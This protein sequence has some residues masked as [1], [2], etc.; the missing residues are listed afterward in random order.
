MLNGNR[1]LADYY[2]NEGGDLST[3]GTFGSGNNAD[4]T[5]YID[6]L[7][8]QDQ[9]GPVV[10]LIGDNPVSIER[11]S[12]YADAGATAFDAGDNAGKTVTTS[13]T[14]DTT[15][16]G[17]YTLTYTAT[18]SRGNIGTATRSVTVNAPASTPPTVSSA[19][20]S[21]VTSASA[22]LG[23]SVQSAGTSDIS[24]RGFV[25]STADTTLEIGAEGVTAVPAEAGL[26]AFTATASGLADG[27]L[28]YFRA[29]ATNETGTSYGEILTFTTLKAEPLVHA[30]DFAA[31]T[32]NSINIAA[33][34]SPVE[35]D[36][37]LLVVSSGAQTAP[38]DGIAVA[39]DTDVSD[40]SAAV[41]LSGTAGSYDAFTGFAV[42]ETYTFRLYPFNNSGAAID[43]KTGSAPSFTAAVLT[44]PEL[45]A[46]GTPAALTT[47]YGTPSAATTFTVSGVYLTSTVS[48]AAPTGFEVSADNATYGPSVTLTPVSGTLAPTMIY[49][50]LAATAAVTGAY[51][52][53][54]IGIDGGGATSV[55]LNT[56]AGGHAV[57]PKALGIVGLS[58]ADKTYDGTTDAVVAGTPLYEGLVNNE[59]FA[60]TGGVSWAFPD[61]NA[62]AG[63]VLAA[64]GDFLA[65]SANYTITEQP[66]LVAEIMTKELTVTGA[67][68]TTKTYD[69]TTDATIT[70]ATL[71]GLVE[72]DT[73]AVS[74][75]GTFN[76][77]DAGENKSVT[78]NLTLGGPDAGNYTLTQPSLT[79][80]ITRADQTITF[81]ALPPKF[82]NDTPFALSATSSAGLSV[83][84]TS[85]N[86]AVATVSGNVVTLLAAGTTTITASQDGNTNFNAATPVAQTLTVNTAQSLVAGWDFQTTDNGGTAVAA[87]PATP[88]VYG[89]NLGSGTLYLDGSHGSSDW[90]VPASGT[91]N[92]ELN[93]FG[94]TDVNATRG[95]STTT[96][97]PAA[98]ALVGGASTAAN[99]KSVVL[100]FS[101]TGLADLAVTYATQRTSSGFTTHAWEY[102]TDGQAWSPLATVN[103]GDATGTIT[104]G[105]AT[106]GAIAL[107]A[108]GV[109][110]NAPTAYLRLTVSGATSATGNNRL[111]NIQLAAGAYVPADTVAPLITVAGED[112]LYLPV[113]AAFI[114]PGVSAF[115]AV[116]GNVEVQTSGT[117]DTA[118][119]S[120]YILTYTATDAAGN[121]ST[122]TREVVVRSG[123]AHFFDTQHGLA[124]VDLG[125]DTDNDG[126]PNLVEYAF[127]TDPTAGAK[128]PAA[129]A[130]QF[131]AEGVQ[132]SAIFRDGDGALTVIPAASTDLRAGWGSAALTEVSADQGGVPPGFRRR[133]WEARGANAALFIRFEV[134]YD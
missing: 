43:Y 67:S 25:Y 53:Q 20:A 42:G 3:S 24:A 109:L 26:G 105:F 66:S 70:G 78:A 83:S 1:T 116:D 31:G 132:F 60:V 23:G 131:T 34:W 14:V 128:Q 93:G 8:N 58:A 38:T 4:N 61:K 89:A 50:R 59:S 84:Y 117:V 92:T 106:S 7:R 87:A 30:A 133:A 13:G 74:G 88:K 10:T 90:F 57:A 85:S 64:T 47:T 51:D 126:T 102:S 72:G 82:A 56:A 35:A 37:Y 6:G 54:T 16:D 32:I 9:D 120:T 63:K 45:S 111:D 17:T 124:G 39:D 97:T 98:L 40:G 113:G 91:T 101:M 118:A 12:T 11:G 96:S 110:D 75:N 114:E 2:L 55:T 99:G 41:N 95:L 134:R 49:L 62:G 107:P 79:G 123:A 36:G 76:N 119:R 104:S 44:T 125:A 115:D 77:A 73:V 48:V 86:E 71:D 46:A 22:T 68:V 130:L 28:H 18:D 52:A 129:A 21:S 19:S 121:E 100:R 15:T 103:S 80:T 5:A 69:G 122:A 108:T 112:P 29:Y 33:T 27:T 65:P 94:G 81:D 127:G